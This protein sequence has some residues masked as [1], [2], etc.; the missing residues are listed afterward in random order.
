MSFTVYCT[1]LAYSK[2]ITKTFINGVPTGPNQVYRK[3]SLNITM[4]QLLNNLNAYEADGNISFELG[5]TGQLI[6]N[7]NVPGT[8]GYTNLTTPTDTITTFDL[9]TITIVPPETLPVLDYKDISIRIFDTYTNTRILQNELAQASA[10][11]ID[12]D[13]G[14]DLYKSI[15]ASKLLFNMYVQ[16]SVDAHFI[17]LFSGDEQRYRVEVV[18][19]ANDLT[20]QLIWRGFLLPDQYQEPYTNGALFVDFTASDMIGSMKGKYLAPWY[21]QNTFPIAQVLSY[22]FAATGLEQNI[23]VNPSVV[24]SNNLYSWQNITVDLRAFIDNDKLTDCY[25]IIESLM[26]SMAMSLYSFRG[27]WWLMGIH[28]KGEVDFTSFQFDSNGTRIA[29]LINSKNLVDVGYALQPTPSFI[30]ITP[31]KKVNV[32]F[33]ADGSKN[34]YSD[35]VVKV[36]KEE[37]S[38]TTYSTG[39]VTI[40][41]LPHVQ[42]EIYGNLC[43]K[44][45]QPTLDW[46]YLLLD[47]STNRLAWKV[48]IWGSSY[49]DYNAGFDGYNYTEANVLNNYIDCLERPYVTPGVLYELQ[50]EFAI[51]NVIIVIN[52]GDKQRIDEKCVAGDYDKLIPWQFFIDGV[53]KYSNRPSINGSNT[54]YEVTAQISDYGD[55]HVNF[56]Y[57]LT[58][59][60]RTDVDGY[61]KFRILMPILKNG[62]N[63]ADS[64]DAN[65][66]I[67]YGCVFFADKLKLTA[68]EGLSENGD[69]SAIRP[70]N[71]T[72]QL[73][74]DLSITST[75]DNSVLSSFGLNTPI[76]NDYIKTIDRTLNA[77]PKW[78]YHFYAP[79][80][81][82]E[83]DL[84]TFQSTSA[85]KKL[86]F[87]EDKKRCCFMETAAGI[88]TEFSSLWYFFNNPTVRIGYLTGYDGYPNIPKGYKYYP[89]VA[90]N[91]VLKYMQVD[92]APE[93]FA[94]RLNWKLYGS[95]IVSNYPKAIARVLHGVQPE[96]VYRLEAGALRLLWPNDLLEFYF[97]D[98]DRVFIPTK[99]NL[100]L[101]A[102]KTSFVATESKFVE[103]SD[104]SYE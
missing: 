75:V 19:V 46:A 34:L 63:A 6:I 48:N 18:G 59:Q 85:L 47:G 3:V 74:H 79:A 91:D 11:K 4:V 64:I 77:Y 1:T 36:A 29:D 66:N 35:R 99:L 22:C 12:S 87:A 2:T 39:N 65:T 14:D 68:L 50:L 100:D 56:T 60:F 49:N 58:F 101:F 97:D 23:I 88:R 57:K 73:D 28:R 94:N 43:I 98:H 17:H 40:G 38:S 24:P 96:M 37:L 90:S 21:Y 86:L 62:V 42:D 102:G 67:G 82:L 83:L 81:A 8:Y 55:Y 76:S 16:D 9:E 103:L 13:G 45:W 69:V 41:T 31:W 52:P 27:Y 92:Y 51:E 95:S 93:N 61:V 78:G 89:N 33:K 26:K 70:I 54:K 30:A 72:Q 32:N 20:E 80:T 25:T 7:F 15:M 5:S 84:Q 104:I 10:C 53:E 71:F 44:S